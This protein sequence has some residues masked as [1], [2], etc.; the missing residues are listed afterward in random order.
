V[1]IVIRVSQIMACGVGGIFAFSAKIVTKRQ[2]GSFLSGF[3][4]ALK[5]LKN[6]DVKREVDAVGG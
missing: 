4:A 1:G 5:K 2:A 6:Y 3:F